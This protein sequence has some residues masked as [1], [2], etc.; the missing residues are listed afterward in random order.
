MAKKKYKKYGG[1]FVLLI[2]LVLAA[3][4]VQP[5]KNSMGDTS[6]GLGYTCKSGVTITDKYI[7]FSCSG[8]VAQD[9]E[10]REGW[11]FNG[12]S[13]NTGHVPVS[14]AVCA[15]FKQTW[16]GQC[17]F[18]NL[19]ALAPYATGSVTATAGTGTVPVCSYIFPLSFSCK[20]T[21]CRG[22]V[23][24]VS[25]NA[26]W[27]VPPTEIPNPIKPIAQGMLSFLNSIWD[28][29]KSLLG[30]SIAGEGTAIAGQSYAYNIN[31]ATTP[32]DTDYKDGAYQTQYAYWALVDASKNIVAGDTKGTEVFGNFIKD[33][34]VTIPA[35]GKYIL[36][37]TI[38]QIDSKW[39][40]TQAKWIDG[41]E[42]IVVKEAKDITSQTTYIQPSKPIAGGINSLLSGLWS[43][44]KGLFGWLGL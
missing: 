40:A 11:G 15:D 37:A 23:H 27:N 28:W 14:Q 22:G 9:C 5:V 41:T 36:V 24:G 7:D 1:A 32:P 33:V 35:N 30:Y 38:T 4:M 34:S 31:L 19:N 25:L 18:D 20:Q 39:D 17:K 8:T 3:S 26:R 16:D 42:T 21:E 29:F 10:L 43:W 44:F 2:L 12:I 6:G 13:D